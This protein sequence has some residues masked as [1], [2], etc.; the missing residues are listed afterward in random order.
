MVNRFYLSIIIVNVSVDIISI[1]IGLI[2]VRNIR[3][4]IVLMLVFLE[5][6]GSQLKF[7]LTDF[8]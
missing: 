4:L 5:C 6:I 1:I 2:I 7:L 8:V 3:F